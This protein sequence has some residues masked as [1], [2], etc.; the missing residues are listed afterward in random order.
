MSL[1]HAR[2][3]V[4][5]ASF[6][7]LLA[8]GAYSQGSASVVD[9]GRLDSN[10]ASTQD[11]AT[12][13]NAAGQVAGQACVGASRHAFMWSAASGMLD[14]GTL[15][16]S[17]SSAGAIN[18]DGAVAGVAELATGAQR[19]FLW[20]PTT[21]MLGLGRLGGTGNDVYAAAVSDN[22]EVVGYS[23]AA[24]GYRHA[25]YWHASR[26]MVDL[27]TL[28]GSAS[29]AFTINNR[30]QVVGASVISSNQSWHGFSWTVDEGM[31]DIGTLGGAASYAVDVND[32]GQVVGWAD[33]AS[34]VTHAVSWTRAGGLIDL[35]ALGGASVAAAVNESGAVVG[36]AS[37]PGTPNQHAFLWTRASGMADLGLL[38]GTASSFATAVT[39]SGVV[40][41]YATATDRSYTR[42]FAWTREGGMVDLGTL[43]GAEAWA[44]AANDEG[45]VVGFSTS[46]ASTSH[47]P[48]M[49]QLPEAVSV[50]VVGPNPIVS[51]NA[52]GA[53]VAISVRSTVG[54]ASCTADGQPFTSG[55]NLGL[56]VHTIVCSA[57]VAATGALRT[58]ETTVSIVLSSGAGAT[59]AMGPAG[60]Q[61]P[62]GPAGPQG[63]QGTTGARG[64]TGPAGPQGPAGVSARQRVA[65]SLTA[66]L[67]P[68]GTLTVTASCPVGKAV[69]GGGG[70]TD[71]TAVVLVASRMQGDTGW[72]VTVVNPTAA[73]RSATVTA[74]GICAIVN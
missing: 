45:Q 58:G 25:F 5:T 66:T 53:A 9:L 17:S 10:C 62:A 15:G 43:G 68:G 49:W 28:G 24:T 19:P 38:P 54:A 40:V 63:I 26:G 11:Q 64:A 44:T 50:A 21:G 14:L 39:A 69:L 35:G 59:G 22:L 55:G 47:R 34:G 48:V 41:G 65:A 13:M 46:S 37:V 8:H 33:L 36:Y 57:R 73:S 51:T 67:A 20:T 4:F 18:A 61:G 23:P 42:A 3:L 71:N 52:T 7:F 60:P 6:L 72:S 56:G 27:G 29:Q 16:G 70:Y 32:V 31:V 30:G 12:A 1:V 74:E 2:S